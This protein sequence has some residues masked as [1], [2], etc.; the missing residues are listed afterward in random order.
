ML[1]SKL[2]SSYCIGL[3]YV[4]IIKKGCKPK[5]KELKVVSLS[6]DE[7]ADG[8]YVALLLCTLKAN[9]HVCTY[10]KQIYSLT[11]DKA[12]KIVSRFWTSI[13]SCSLVLSVSWVYCMRGHLFW[14]DVMGNEV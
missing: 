12:R 11:C 4:K 7:V 5:Q 13:L 14:W 3:V 6:L 8:N 9:E 10:R 1:L 2:L